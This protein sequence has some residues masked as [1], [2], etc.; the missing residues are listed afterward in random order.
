[1]NNMP[2]KVVELAAKHRLP[3]IYPGIS[4]FQEG[5]LISYAPSITDNYR[6]AAAY[7]DKILKG[8]NPG[9]LPVQDPKKI[10]LLINLKAAQDIGL[11]IPQSILNRAD[12]LIR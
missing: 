6:C 3:A 8:A 11:S 10:D 12:K 2:G 1:M 4:Y 5:G 7:I 9:D